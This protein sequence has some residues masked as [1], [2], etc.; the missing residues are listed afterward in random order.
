[1][2]LG[3]IEIPDLGFDLGELI[4][5]SVNLLGSIVATAVGG[6]VAFLLVRRALRWM[7]F[8]LPSFE[9]SACSHHSVKIEMDADF[10]KWK[11]CCDCGDVLGPAHGG[12][13][14]SPDGS[15]SGCG[16]PT[17][18]GSECQSCWAERNGF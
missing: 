3:D 1:M 12:E 5:A 18:G 6:Y 15:C 4:S 2:F 9:S 7:V 17:Y 11:I 10:Q 16:A 8:A 14:V 13:A